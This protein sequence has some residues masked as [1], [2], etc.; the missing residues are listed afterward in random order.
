MTKMYPISRSDLMDSI[1]PDLMFGSSHC[2]VVEEPKASYYSSDGDSIQVSHVE[3]S[4]GKISL[5]RWQHVHC[6]HF[7]PCNK[8]QI[9]LA[10]RLDCLHYQVSKEEYPTWIESISKVMEK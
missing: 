2:F 7:V 1:D 6:I 4:K 5:E 10:R 3:A 8:E 9:Y